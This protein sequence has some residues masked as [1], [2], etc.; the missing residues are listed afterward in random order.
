MTDT[1]PPSLDQLTASFIELR[2]K[3]AVLSRE[4]KDAESAVVADMDAIKRQLLDYCDNTG[5][6]GARTKSGMFFRSTNTRYWASDW[7]EMHAFIKDNDAF[8]F[9]EKRLS[10]GAVKSFIDENPDVLLPG[11]KIDNEYVVTVRSQK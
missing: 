2:D 6:E 1:K 9:L 11:L 5:V 3:K 4:F 8:D 7:A 10:Q